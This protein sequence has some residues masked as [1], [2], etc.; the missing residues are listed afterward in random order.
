MKLKNITKAVLLFVSLAFIISSCSK[1]DDTDTGIFS[2]NMVGGYVLNSGGWGYNNSTLSF[3]NTN[4]STLTSEVFEKQNKG[5]NLGDTGNDMLIYGD[6]MYIVVSTSSII[7]VTNKYGIKQDSI[8]YKPNGTLLEPRHLA[9]SGNYVYVSYYGG[10]VAR[11]NTS[12]DKIDKQIQ[13]GDYPEEIA[14]SNGNLYV[15]NSS[16]MSYKDSTVTKIDLNSFT[17]SKDINVVLNP[18]QILADGNG[19]LFVISMGNYGTIPST[20]QKIKSDGTITTIGNASMMAFNANASKLYCIYSQYDANWN[21]TYSY[22]TYNISSNAVETNPF[23]SS[24]TSS[25]LVASPCS[26]SVN[27]KDGY[28]YMGVSDYSSESTMYVIDPST[29]NIKTSFKTGGITPMGIY[30]L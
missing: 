22:F 8:V 17:K 30:F 18:T 6:K 2:G 21:T 12:T 4:T 24:T 9:A 28:I 16:Y 13:V 25:Q 15:T 27:P 20:L 23:V 14:V 19:N 7:Y 5:L 29:G 3:Y 26:L 10:Y 11:I 1:D